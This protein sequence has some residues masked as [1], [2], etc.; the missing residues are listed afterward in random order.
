[1]SI[2]GAIGLVVFGIAFGALTFITVRKAEGQRMEAT[3][4]R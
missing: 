3:G 1:M 4:G 2:S